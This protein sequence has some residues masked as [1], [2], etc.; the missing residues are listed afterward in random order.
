MPSPVRGAFAGT[1]ATYAQSQSNMPM[2]FGAAL[3]GRFARDR[4]GLA[5]FVLATDALVLSNSV[6]GAEA[7]EQLPCSPHCRPASRPADASHRM[8][9][10]CDEFSFYSA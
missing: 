2:L 5:A 1:A 9:A 7:Q 8:T 10:C 6:A 3:S 4:P